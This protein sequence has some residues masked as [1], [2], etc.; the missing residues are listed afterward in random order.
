VLILGTVMGWQLSGWRKTRLGVRAAVAASIDNYPQIDTEMIIRIWCAKVNNAI[1]FDK[2]TD[3]EGVFSDI[4]KWMLTWI[5]SAHCST[6]SQHCILVEGSCHWWVCNL[7]KSYFWLRRICIT[8]HTWCCGPV[9]Q[10][11]IWL[12]PIFW[13][14]YKSC[15]LCRNGKRVV[16]TT[17]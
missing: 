15:I 8:H 7:S 17:V 12:A 16:N 14:T 13:W 1:S 6:L 10:Q 2:R 4:Q 11:L 5:T 9:W 3:C